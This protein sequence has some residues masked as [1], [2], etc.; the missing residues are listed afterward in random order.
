MQESSPVLRFLQTRG[1]HRRCCVLAVNR[2][3]RAA[4]PLDSSFRRSTPPS[5]ARLFG[6][7]LLPRHAVHRLQNCTM[8]DNRE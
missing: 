7:P 4:R 3:H 5:V 6:P 8:A 2:L 1:N